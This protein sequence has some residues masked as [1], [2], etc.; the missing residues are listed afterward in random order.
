M[1]VHNRSVLTQCG[2]RIN[3]ACCNLL[4]QLADSL[5]CSARFL[6]RKAYKVRQFE[7]FTLPINVAAHWCKIAINRAAI[8]AGK[9]KY[10]FVCPWCCSAERYFS[11]KVSRSFDTAKF[12]SIV[13]QR[14]MCCG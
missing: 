10:D 3:A 14:A 8:I 4:R 2:P 9:K 6:N 5:I 1:N 11:P 7:V 12:Q 13:G